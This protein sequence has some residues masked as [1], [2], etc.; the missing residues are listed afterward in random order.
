MGYPKP[1]RGEVWMF[2]LNPKKGHE[3]KGVRPCLVVSTDALNRSD[4]GTVI[5]CPI[6]TTGHPSFKWRIAIAPGDLRLADTD[7]QPKPHWVETDQIVTVDTRHRALRHLATVT[8]DDKLRSV[9]ES[10]R[11]MLNL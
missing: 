9:D 11:M 8:N 10:L 3:Q 2:D 1:L 4:F 7:W 6:T 5:V